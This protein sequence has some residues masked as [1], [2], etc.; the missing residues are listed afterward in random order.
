M[1]EADVRLTLGELDLAAAFS[2]APGET[3]AVLGPN[4][5]GK[6]T[7]LRALGGLQRHEGR[8]TL[9]G[10]VLDDGP[11]R[12]HVHPER[13]NAGF[14]FQDHVLFPH[15]SA[16]DNVGFGLRAKGLTKRAAAHEAAGWLSKVGLDGFAKH[17]PAQLSG[18]QRQRVAL[19]RALAIRPQLLLLD[20]PTA[21]LDAPS[22]V[23]MRRDLAA[24]LAAFDGIR[25][26][27]THDAL[28]AA[29]LAQQL[30][31]LEAGKVVQQG[32]LP[33]VTARPRSAYVADLA[34]LNLLLGEADGG[35]VLLD[36]GA[37]VAAPSP[38]RGAVFVTVH[39]RAVALHR[40]RPEGTPRNVWAGTPV[41][42]ELLGDR[43]RVQVLGDAPA[44]A[45][46]AEVTPAAVSALE[47]DRGGRVWVSVK[48]TELNVYPR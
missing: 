34:G 31:I 43:A 9:A 44:P 16:L 33:E 42:V 4:A 48:A 30:L 7:L 8:V 26:L 38:L 46:V 17:R 41:G 35:T 10:R 32:S 18:G 14:V 23:G 27:V 36:S 11:G 40:H 6:S 22:R 45:L 24:Q 37:A 20:E 12:R 2:V 39:P 15:L 1:L 5:A 13:R 3:L 25:I 29:A 21:S 28:E 47:L 19:A